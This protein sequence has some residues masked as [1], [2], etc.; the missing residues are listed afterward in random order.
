MRKVLVFGGSGFVGSFICKELAKNGFNVVSLSKTG[1]NKY[2]L[3]KEAKQIRFVKAD[4]FSDTHWQDELQNAY[5]V[6]NCIGILF[7]HK[8]K[9]ITY[10]KFIFESTQH[11][12]QAAHV[13]DVKRFVQ[14]S[15]I[16]PPFFILRKYHFYKQASEQFLQS[17]PFHLCII[18]PAILVAPQKPFLLFLY[19]LQEFLHLPIKQFE[20]LH[21][22]AKQV[23][24]FLK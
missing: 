16:K 5:A 9:D 17:M 2:L 18:R 15:A 21:N 20:S 11:I 7:E 6:I 4:L 14:I 3:E 22:V 12:A 19:R 10:K 8:S 24:A 13:H 23:L 1:I